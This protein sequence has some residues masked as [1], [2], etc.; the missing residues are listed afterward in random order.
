MKEWQSLLRLDR[1]LRP[2]RRPRRH[3]LGRC[4]PGGLCGA[5]IPRC[6]P[7]C[8][9]RPAAPRSWPQPTIAALIWANVEPVHIPPGVDDAPVGAGRRPWHHHRS[10]GV[11]ELGADGAVLPGRRAGGAARVRC[12]RA[13]GAQRARA[14]GAGRA[15]RH[16][17]PGRHLP[18]R[19]RG[20]AVRARVGHVDV[21]RHRVR[22]RR[23]GAGRPAAA[24]PGA[25]LPADLL[26][27]RRPGRAR[28]HRHRV[29][30]PDRREAA[31]DRD[32]VPGHRG[33]DQG[34]RGAV[35][36]RLRG[37]G[38]R[39]VGG[40]LLLGRGPD[41]GGPGHGAD[42]VRLPGH[43]G[44]AGAG[45][46]GVPGVPR[47]AHRGTGAV[48]ARR[49]AGGDLAERPAGAAVPPVV[50]LPDRAAVRAGQR[51]DRAQ[52]LVPGP[53]VHLA[54]HARPHRRLPGRQAARAP[55][56]ARGWSPGSAAGGCGRQSGG[57][58]SW[59]PGRWPG[60]GSP[61]RC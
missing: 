22:A 41:R 15:G 51:R 32:R 21:D 50:E 25:H 10:A 42:V 9:P 46:R 33:G 39:G 45:V 29:Q 55:R 6:V 40:V 12:G 11:R 26:G 16:D 31:A 3:R 23:A 47:A 36:A 52:R 7:S 1:L 14:A 18:G 59:V 54:D 4:S 8:A 49:G 24:G 48:G 34:S 38:D 61:C 28:R 27:G 53:G 17:R 60:S 57:V 13:A 44:V 56:L 19:E 37:T 30:R 35:R 20:A 58:R 2:R 5:G 43:A